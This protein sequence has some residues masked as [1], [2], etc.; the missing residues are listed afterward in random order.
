MKAPISGINAATAGIDYVLAHRL[1]G[2]AC[3]MAYGFE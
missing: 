2:S 1:K 3:W